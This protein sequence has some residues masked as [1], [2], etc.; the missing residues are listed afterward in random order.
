MV[1][2]RGWTSHG[3]NAASKVQGGKM[4]HIWGR[5]DPAGPHV[6]PMNFVIWDVLLI[7]IHDLRLWQWQYIGTFGMIWANDWTLWND[8]IKWKHDPRYWPFVRGINRS[9]VDFPHKGQL[10][11]ALMLSLTGA[12]INGWANNRDAVDLRRRRAHNDVTVMILSDLNCWGFPL[13]S[14]GLCFW[15]TPVMM[16]SW[17]RWLVQERRN[18]SALTMELRLFD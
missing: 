17:Y 9:P 15:P 12:M 16:T 4:G 11:G 1:T 3:Y 10:R 5:Q 8:V 6:G 13:C 18:F 14:C 2:S 7:I